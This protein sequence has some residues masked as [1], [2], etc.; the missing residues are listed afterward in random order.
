MIPM[1]LAEIAHAVGGEL[2]DDG[3][4]TVEVVGDVFHDSRQVV[5]GGLFVAIRGERVDGHDFAAA[6]V[7]AGAAAALV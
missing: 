3:D 1:T 2:A 5:A 6:C 4:G 7:E